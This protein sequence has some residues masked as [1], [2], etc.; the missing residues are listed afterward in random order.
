[1]KLNKNRKLW[2]AYSTIALIANILT[3]LSVSALAVLGV[4]SYALA[5]PTVV[6]LAV[7]LVFWASLG[8]L[9]AKILMMTA[10]YFGKKMRKI[11]LPRKGERV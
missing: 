9:F 4:I 2:K 6:C 3:A 7:F 5:F 8:G 1:M 11:K 10:S